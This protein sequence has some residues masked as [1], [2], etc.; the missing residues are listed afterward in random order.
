MK[1]TWILA[2][3]RVG[4]IIR[5]IAYNQETGAM[6]VMGLGKAGKKKFKELYR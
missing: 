1:Y 6:K 3:E 2:E 5:Y 4:M